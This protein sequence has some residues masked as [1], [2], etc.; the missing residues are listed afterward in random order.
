MS[1]ESGFRHG[2]HGFAFRRPPAPYPRKVGS[3][4]FEEHLAQRFHEHERRVT[5]RSK[6]RSST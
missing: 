3:R 2:G 5:G 6:K 4:K 1:H